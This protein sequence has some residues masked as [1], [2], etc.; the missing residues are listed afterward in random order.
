MHEV[1]P[2]PTVAVLLPTFN[3]ENFLEEQLESLLNQEGVLTKVYV[4][5]DASTDKTVQIL[6]KY[7]KVFEVVFSEVNIGTTASLLSL[8]HLAKDYD[9]V[10]FCD[11]DDVWASNHLVLAVQ[12]LMNTNKAIGA[13]Y[14][15][16]YNYIDSQSKL[17]GKR[18]PVGNIGSSNALVE[19]PIIGCGLVFN[20]FAAG[21]IKELDFSA[22]YFLDHQIYFLG[23]LIGEIHQGSIYTINYR[24]HPGNQVGISSGAL[25]LFSNLSRVFDKVNQIK[26]QQ[27]ALKKIFFQIAKL[28][29]QDSTYVPSQH[30]S[31]VYSRNVIVRFK[32]FFYPQ[33]RRQKRLDQILFRLVFV[34]LF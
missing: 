7:T 30:F 25:D 27:L 9:F 28:I 22:N 2:I 1:N 19:N 24:I 32:Y 34:L 10:A 14:F 12:G 5:D 16:Q 21:K 20:E 23:S 17:I 15:P 11:Q 18:M 31:A 6:K 13:F 4:R 33:F 3:G 8:L 29:P 26:V